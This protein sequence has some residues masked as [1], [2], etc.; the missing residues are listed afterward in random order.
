[1]SPATSAPY[2]ISAP[3]DL[4]QAAL[5]VSLTGFILF[6][7]VFDVADPA[8]LT[9]LAYVH[10]NPAAQRMLHLPECPADSFRTRYP[11]AVDTGIFAFYRD[12]FLVGGPGRYDVNYTHEGLDNYYQL[13]A[14]RAG[15]LLVVSFS[16][17]A[18]QPCT[19]VEEAL[20]QSR[21]REQEA[22]ADAER[23]RQR[24]YDV[25]M[26]LP[27]QVAT[28]HSPDHVFNF[29]NP[30]FSAFVAATGLL[31]YPV[32]A[33]AQ[34]A[35]G[36][37]VFAL[38]DRVYATGEPVQLLEL[39]VAPQPHDDTPV[40]SLFINAFYLPLRDGD[41]HIYGVLDFS[42]EVTEQVLARR[43]VQQL[44][45]ELAATNEK[46]TTSNQE[47]LLANT[48]LHAAQQQLQHLT[49]EL[50]A[51]VQQRTRQLGQQTNRLERL[52]SEAP[53]AIAVLAGP[54]LVFEFVNAGYQQLFPNRALRNKPVVEALPELVGGPVEA[55]LRG[56]Y[57]T[58]RTYEGS[59]VRMPFARPADGLVEDRYFNFIYQARYG[60]DGQI[61]GLVVLAFEVTEP[62]QARQRTAL[63]QADV[64]AASQRQVQ[65]HETLYQ[66]FAQTAAAIC[67]VRGPGHR[68][69]Y[70]NAAYQQLF[71][72]RE[73][74]GRTLAE[75]IPESVADGFVALLDRVYQTGETFQGCELPLLLRVPD[76]TPQQRYYTFT[77]QATREQGQIVGIS[78]FAYDVSEQVQTRQAQQ[79]QQRQLEQLFMQ[80]PAP[81]VILEGPELVFQLVNP[82][83][84]RIFPGRE[85]VDKPL[86]DALPELVDT[87]IPGLFR[88]VYQTG[89]PVVVQEMPLMM[90]RY[91]GQELEEIYW[92]F[93]YQARRDAH[94]VIDGVRV[95]AHDVTEQVRT[96]H[97]VAASA[98]QAQA[99]A[100]SL[101]ETNQQLTRVNVDLDTFVYAASHDLKA[102][103]ANIE[104]LLSVLR[105]Y[106]P[107]EAQEPMVPRLLG[108]MEGAIARFQQTVGHLTDVSHLHHLPHEPP[109]ATL[110]I[111]QVVED[112]CLDLQPLLESTRAE[113]VVAVAACPGVHFSATNLR[114]VFFN[115]LSNALKY[116]APDRVPR[117]HVR[118]QCTDEQ[119]VLEVQDNGLGLSEQQQSQL[120]TMFRRL[121]T[122]VEGSGVGLYLIKRTIENAGG[123][124]TVQ[125]RPDVGSTFTVTLPRI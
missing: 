45:E 54:D 19:A 32:R 9:D 125:S 42:Y 103:I 36:P 58:G 31:G 6:R 95:F 12:T 111:P 71:P 121:H 70:A 7:P 49:Q 106:L 52:L 67:L 62:V 82:A 8:M 114:S 97:A 34:G 87:P 50:E 10:L 3:S 48:A 85:L 24:F 88:Q 16:D 75:A 91:E 65:E 41:G 109:T 5:E 38:L 44:N 18:D 105:E 98:Q 83:Y 101:A 64:L 66:V 33:V 28:Y 60:E 84:Q 39:A 56:V 22:R 51:R 25:L 94:G 102:P 92:T 4:L 89:E 35:V 110:N 30:R 46:L 107:T 86:L 29:V 43:Q 117:V 115:L 1:M 119:L 57:E 79:V 20:R 76:G 90:A 72:E 99:L 27:A 96:R 26:Q 124:I 116:R 78:V 68:F 73:L 74:L 13:A 118:T 17:T 21:L 47:Y 81:I 59:E 120:F 40:N 11:R 77:Y 108:M 104:G 61:D 122:H 93:T 100:A 112:V 69:A 80:A 2:L 23:E 63:L 55:M 14:R 123:I 15:D 53:A 113:L 37:E